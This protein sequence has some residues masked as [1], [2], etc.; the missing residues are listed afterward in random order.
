MATIVVE[1]PIG[2]GKTTL[3][4]YLADDLGARLL[5]E[6]VEENPFLARFYEDR[7]RY[8]FQTETFFLLS[9]FRQH[10]EL[11]QAS[12]FTPH[13]VA[14]YLFD[15]TFLFASLTLEGDEFE[16]YRELFLQLRSRLPRP[17]LVVY[18]RAEPDVLLERIRRRGRPFE[19]GIEA[20]YLERITAAYDDL[21]ARSEIP[22]EV[23]DAGAIDF[24]A[25]EGQRADL[26]A[27]LRASAKAA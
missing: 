24:V 14:D 25:D 8:A 19:A 20:G 9:R 5:L 18:L 21:F 11:A 16:L 26:L 27:L 15:K 1:G 17:D 7:R 12:L 10:S 3:A 4:R 6:V 23:V 13:T 2:V 22:V